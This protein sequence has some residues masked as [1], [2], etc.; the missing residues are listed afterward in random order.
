M[1]KAQTSVLMVT[2]AVVLSF[3]LVPGSQAQSEC[4]PL[5][6][7]ENLTILE[8]LER[9]DGAQ[10]F[11]AL[12]EHAAAVRCPRFARLLDRA[13]ASLVT[14]V[15]NNGG[16]EDLFNRPPGEFDGRDIEE[17]REVLPAYLLDIDWKDRDLCRFL[18]RHISKSEAKT[19]QELLDR[20]FITMLNGEELPVAVGRGG[21]TFA[22]EA[23]ITL[24]V[25]TQNGV[26]Q[27]LDRVILPEDEPS[28]DVVTVFVTQTTYQG[29][30]GGLDPDA[31][32][33]E[34]AEA[35]GLPGTDWTAWLSYNTE[36]AI[37]R[38]PAGQYRLVDGITVVAD[39]KNDLT[40]GTLK[41]LITLNEY[42]QPQSGIVWT[43]TNSDGT[44][45]GNT[46]NDWTDASSE[47]G[48]CPDPGDPNCGSVGST[49]ATNAEWTKLNAAPFQCNAQY[50]L[51][52]FGVSQ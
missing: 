12:V 15:P 23:Q 30:L 11:V 32:C 20:G 6:D 7:N 2:F 10:A 9:T 49:S 4:G 27:Y 5:L 13:R 42:G 8:S 45:T 47:Q 50:S 51:Y 48:G 36:D 37:D 16:F 26:I 19:V 22:Y 3:V 39:N 35:A 18:R 44:G 41:A 17:I 29:D 25:L 52:C 40:D 21:V 38:I 24:G 31:I 34:R 46:C 14:L 33:E 1:K 28:G 43:A